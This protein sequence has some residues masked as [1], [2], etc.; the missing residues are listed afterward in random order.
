MEFNRLFDELQYFLS[1]FTSGNTARQVRH[2][3]SK[4]IFTFF[5]NHGVTHILHASRLL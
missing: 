4:T 5:D 2:I 1:R 3:R